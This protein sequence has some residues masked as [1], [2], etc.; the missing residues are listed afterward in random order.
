MGTFYSLFHSETKLCVVCLVDPPVKPLWPSPGLDHDAGQ[1]KHNSPPGDEEIHNWQRTSLTCFLL[2]NIRWE[3]VCPYG[4]LHDMDGGFSPATID[5][6]DQDEFGFT[7]K[8]ISRSLF[9]IFTLENFINDH[10]RKG[11]SAW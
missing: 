7:D 9:Y 6:Y 1:R 8:V 2:D 4:E 10:I 3:S 5:D 11:L